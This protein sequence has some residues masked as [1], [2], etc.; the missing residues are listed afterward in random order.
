QDFQDFE[1]I[2]V[3]D[4]STDG[5]LQVAE[6]FTDNRIKIF[7]QANSGVSH[8]RNTGAAKA[9]RPWAA[10]L[11]ADDWWGP[12]FLSEMRAAILKFPE[13]SIFATGRSRSFKN[14]TERYT[15]RYLPDGGRTAQL[16]YFEV[17]Q[18]A[19]PPM[20]VSSTVIERSLLEKEKFNERLT[21]YEDHELWLR[22]S[23][24]HPVVF[25]NK[26]LSFYRKD[27]AGTATKRGLTA[28]NFNEYLSSLL[29]LKGAIKGNDKTCFQKYANRFSVLVY[30]KFQ[31]SF[32][33][34][35]REDVSIK[36]KQLVTGPLRL[37][38]WGARVF[39]IDFY[40]IA[41]KMK[42]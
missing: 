8:A 24:L 10:F 25:V 6:T 14:R 11:D 30:L 40:A 22:L 9:A 27:I 19:L 7:T 13:R 16:N 35:E 33:K 41:K 26:P 37:L 39:P 38:F 36:I 2:V 42:K 18:N 34:V 4:G 12:S 15:N 1:V 31:R 21:Q 3:N 23:I 29:K 20:H 32:T 17:V 5:S 28:K